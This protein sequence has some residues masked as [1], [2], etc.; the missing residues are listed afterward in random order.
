MGPWIVSFG[1]ALIMAARPDPAAT[2]ADAVTLRDGSGG[3]GQLVDSPP[4]NTVVI[5]VRREWAHKALPEWAGRW[6]SAEEAELA[7]AVRRRRERLTAW[8]RERVV[9]DEKAD[10]ITPWLDRELARLADAD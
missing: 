2:A 3:L 1:L 7:R 6:E 5:H 4:R 10:R 8:R 9:E